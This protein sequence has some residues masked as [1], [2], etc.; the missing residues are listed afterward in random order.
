MPYHVPPISVTSPRRTPGS[1]TPHLTALTTCC[2]GS[3][4]FEHPHSILNT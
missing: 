3:F 1:N 4:H 2:S